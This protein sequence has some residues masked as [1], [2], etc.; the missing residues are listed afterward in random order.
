MKKRVLIVGGGWEEHE[1]KQCA[2]LFA[3]L[4]AERGFDV[5]VRDTLD[6]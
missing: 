6:A 1:P 3:G 5:V 4:L 2:E